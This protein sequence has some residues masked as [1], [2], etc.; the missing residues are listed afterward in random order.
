[1]F[2]RSS[3]LANIT[4]PVIRQQ[5][6][7][8]VGRQIDKRLVIRLA[9]VTQ[10]SANQNWDIFP[11]FAQRRHGDAHHVEAKIKVVAEF[12]FAHELLE[13]FVRG[14]N[15]PHIGVQGL[16]AADPLK[17]A[18]LAHDTKQFDLGARVDLGHFV[19]ENRATVGLLEP[20]DSPFVCACERAFLV[21]E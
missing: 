16:I 1:M 18:V 12:S 8:R 17:C 5:R 2:D 10:E 19:E 4:R 6:V 14:S 3:Q 11:S 20:A 13:I 7:R 9:E 15:D 21:T